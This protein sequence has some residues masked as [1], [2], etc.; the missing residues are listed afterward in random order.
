MCSVRV[1][2]ARVIPDLDP[3][4]PPHRPVSFYYFCHIHYP[5]DIG[6]QSDIAFVFALHTN[7]C[8]RLLPHEFFRCIAMVSTKNG[9]FTSVTS[10]IS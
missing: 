2:E 8:S 1:S 5:P 3:Q 10:T 4:R 7:P 9:R 6:V